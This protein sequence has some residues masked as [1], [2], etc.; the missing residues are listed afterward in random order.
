MKDLI[1][2]FSRCYVLSRF[3]F[4]FFINYSKGN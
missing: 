2:C 1:L 4:V 3:I